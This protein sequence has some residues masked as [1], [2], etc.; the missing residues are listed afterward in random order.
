MQ[1]Y[2]IYTPAFDKNIGGICALHYLADQL[3]VRGAQHV[4]LTAP[5]KN[6]RW[7][8]ILVDS[9]LY[10]L[11]LPTFAYRCYRFLIFLRSFAFFKTF[12]RKINRKIL[13]LYPLFFWYFFDRENTV[14]I[15]PENIKGNP[16]EARHVVRWVLNDPN[17]EQG[18]GV[19]EQTD[20]IFKYHEFYKVDSK[21]A[22][23]GILTA[24]DLEYHLKTYQNKHYGHRAGGAY[25][26]K[27]GHHKRINQHPESYP[28][29]DSLFLGLTDGEK[30]EY[31]NQIETFISYDHMTFLSVQA[32]LCGCESIIIPDEL[33]AYTAEQLK[34][35][36]PLSG[37][38]YGF[39][40]LINA[41]RTAHLLRPYFEKLNEE[42]LQTISDFKRYCDINIFK[43]G[44]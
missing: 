6:S 32:A 39:D 4:Y 27:K 10:G 21:Y 31:F 14:V 38:A 33:G 23:K 37:I 43:V 42:Q 8:G 9:V 16:L 25:L 26:I 20:H 41:K 19:Y 34:S 11:K 44:Q 5:V 29:V 3:I 24:I 15:Y 35:K 28:C 7:Q 1:A 22:V 40:D 30:A 17:E 18:F 13:A 36:N 2:L 12:I